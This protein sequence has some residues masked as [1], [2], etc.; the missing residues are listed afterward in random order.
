MNRKCIPMCKDA[1][2]MGVSRPFPSRFVLFLLTFGLLFIAAG[3]ASA[4]LNF[5]PDAGFRE[6]RILVKPIATVDLTPLHALLGVQVLRAYPDIGGLEVLQLP[7]GA[8]VPGTIALYQQSGLVQYTEPDLLAEA[9]A[10]PNEAHFGHNS[11]RALNNI[12]TLRARH[13]DDT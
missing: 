13:D 3:P 2:S 9:L 8:T 12:A 5:P 7:L 4:Q 6:D 11:I 1:P 10:A